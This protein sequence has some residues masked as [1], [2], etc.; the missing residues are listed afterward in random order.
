MEPNTVF[1][2]GFM[3]CWI[4]LASS[5][6]ALTAPAP[7]AARPVAARLYGCAPAAED[8]MP[9]RACPRRGVDALEAPARV[10]R[11]PAPS[12]VPTPCAPAIFPAACALNGCALAYAFP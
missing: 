7:A 6:E 12:A 5:G 8:W 10:P 9:E 3:Y 2:Y 4:E 11:L 1:R